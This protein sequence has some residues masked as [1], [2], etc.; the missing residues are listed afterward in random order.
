MR[1]TVGVRFTGIA[2]ALML[3]GVSPVL[4]EIPVD[5]AVSPTGRSPKLLWTAERQAVW[6]RMKADYESNRRSKPGQWFETLKKSAECG[7][8]YSD[9]GMWA[10]VMYQV[11]GEAKYAKLAWGRLAGGFLKRSGRALGGNYAREYSAE[12]V[13]M[14]D[15][16]F[17]GLTSG[18]RQQFLAKLNEMFSL[19][20]AGNKHTGAMPIR[21]S[22]T[23]Q[24]VG[25]Y[26]GF[27]FL[28]LATGD[29]NPTADELFASSFIG[30]LNPTAPGRMTLRNAIKEYV[31]ELAAGGEWMES[32]DYNLGTVRLLAIGAEGVRT[33]TGVD[34]F[35]EI[36]AYLRDAALRQIYMMTPDRRSSVQW[37]DEQSPR[38][39]AGRLFSWQTTNGVLAGLTQDDVESGPYIQRL[40]FDLADQ[41]G[42]SGYL[43]SEPWAR[44]FLFFN[45]YARTAAPTATL[46]LSRFSPGQG[47]LVVRDGWSDTSTLVAIHMPTK[48]GSVDHQVSYFG[49]FQI[50]RKGTWALTHPISYGGPS[51]RGDGANAMIIGSFSSMA[52][53]KRVTAYEHGAGGTFTYISGTTGGQ[54]S[55]EGAYDPPP[56]FLHE[57]TRS[58]VYL[59]SSDQRSDSLIVYDRTNA[60]NP[61]ELPKFARYR[62]AS[63]DEQSAILDMPAL[64]Q[65]VIHAPVDPMLSNEGMSWTLPDGQHVSVDTLLPQPQRRLVYDERKLWTTRVPAA[66]RK[67]QV[68]ILPTVD[69]QWDTFLNVVQVFDDGA[70]LANS[71][72][73]SDDK[74]VEGVIVKRG[75]HDDVVALFNSA[76]GP[77]LLDRRK[78]P[79]S[80]F[81]ASVTTTLDRVRVRPGGITVKWTSTTASTDVLLFDLDRTKTWR[82]SI[83]GAAASTLRVSTQGVA[84]VAV[85][86]IGA[87]SLAVLSN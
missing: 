71:V 16:L 40:V 52:Q 58:I 11:T 14:Y 17:P 80:V 48:H 46:P 26:F 39:V 38:Q 1:L 45:P 51:S 59:P 75:G 55:A 21:T 77:A 23:D 5:A 66:E 53:F 28:A 18:Q 22:D 3:I 62:R 73:R 19:L 8:K 49:D 65:W 70:N 7:C 24:T 27:A 20:A 47:M 86:G 81:D 33:A 10:T 9:N 37:G 32:S 78:G 74:T 29:H 42:M 43:S 63:P 30:G 2:F 13:V 25:S 64:K 82:V 87:H 85:Q 61:K 31:S 83:D 67:W 60:Q 41:Y 56:T 50:Y 68:R 76:S 34:H 72:L 57:W 84:T 35:P 54:K 69:Q 79:V 4:R 44:F 36:T 6:S 12:L 15:W